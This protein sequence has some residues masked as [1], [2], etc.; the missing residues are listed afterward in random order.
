MS[1]ST[2]SGCSSS[3]ASS[4][5]APVCA[6]PDDLE[7]G[8]AADERAVHLGHHEVVVDDEHAD[9]RA[10]T[11]SGSRAENTAPPSSL[12]T[13]TEPPRRTQIVRVSASPNPR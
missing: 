4:A 5:A 2:R 7:P 1:S 12:R 6:T 11:A 13:P 9:H 8:R 10:G 3:A